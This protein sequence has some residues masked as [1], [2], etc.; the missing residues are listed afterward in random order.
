M[1]TMKVG[2]GDIRVYVPRMKMELN[3]L[4]AKR[5]GEDANLESTST[6]PRR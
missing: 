6:A 3:E 1:K 2:I 5:V 4:I